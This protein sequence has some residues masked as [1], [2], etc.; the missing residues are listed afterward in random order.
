MKKL[1]PV[2]VMILTWTGAGAQHFV[3]TGVNDKFISETGNNVPVSPVFRKPSPEIQK[4]YFRIPGERQIKVGRTLTILGGAFLIGGI[5]VYARA[6]K[7][8]TYTRY[9]NSYNQLDSVAEF[10]LKMVMG[11]LMMVAGTAMAVPGVLLWTKGVKKNRQYMKEQEGLSLGF[12]RSS[13]VLT[14]RF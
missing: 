13:A 6:D 11:P 1:F 9:T 7:N 4:S 5:S 12:R 2:V 14:Y 10:D 3:S 8:V